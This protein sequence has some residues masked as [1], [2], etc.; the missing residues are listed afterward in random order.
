V[1]RQIVLHV[2]VV[3]VPMPAASRVEQD[4]IWPVFKMD[5]DV[6]VARHMDPGFGSAPARHRDLTRDDTEIDDAPRARE[7]DRRINTRLVVLTD[8][9][10]GPVPG[11]V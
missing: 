11:L 5:R 8:P 1:H 9:D 2:V 7:W 10:L 4:A 3:P 6:P